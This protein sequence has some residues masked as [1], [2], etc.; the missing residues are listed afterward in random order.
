MGEIAFLLVV[1]FLL[2]FF[3]GFRY[4]LAGETSVLQLADFF[5]AGFLVVLVFP[6]EV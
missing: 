5:F 3:G 1:V 2:F 6:L 4:S